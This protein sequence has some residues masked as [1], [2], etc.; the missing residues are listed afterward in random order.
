L[1]ERDN[2]FRAAPDKIETLRVGYPLTLPQ[3]FAR[4]RDKEYFS[5]SIKICI[6]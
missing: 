4:K 1:K 5:L 3:G 6:K 2:F